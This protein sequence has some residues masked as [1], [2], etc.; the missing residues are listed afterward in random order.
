M[1]IASV[2]AALAADRT[3]DGLC[4]WVEAEVLRPVDLPVAGVRPRP[5]PDPVSSAGR[6]W[7][8]FNGFALH[9]GPDGRPD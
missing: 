8:G 3:L 1:T 4:D 9:L 2:G 7:V 5:E 6:K